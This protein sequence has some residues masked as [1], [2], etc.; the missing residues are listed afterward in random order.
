MKKFIVCTV[1]TL[2]MLFGLYAAQASEEIEVLWTNNNPN[3]VHNEAKEYYVVLEIEKE[4]VVTSIMT[5]HYF[6]GGA[7]PGTIMLFSESGAQWGPFQ[8]EGIDGQGDVKNAYWLADVGEIRLAPGL[9]AIADSDQSTW[10]ANEASDYYG[11]AELRGYYPVMENPFGLAEDS[12][13][14]SAEAAQSTAP[15]D[16]SGSEFGIIDELTGFSFR[17]GIVFGMTRDKVIGC[18][19]GNSYTEYMGDD[20]MY[21]GLETPLGYADVHYVFDDNGM[22]ESIVVL[23]AYESTDYAEDFALYSNTDLALAAVFGQPDVKERYYRNAEGVSLH[24]MS[25]WELDAVY[26]NHS[27]QGG[28]TALGEQHILYEIPDYD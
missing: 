1:L 26:I 3:S 14:I 27:A 8:A 13:D 20:L 24:V 19:Q 10:S 25:Y 11:I 9:Y 4:C 21:W 22:L 5:Y 23:Q 12:A 7:L 16:I 18:E 6:N 2:V 28:D 15:N 17:N